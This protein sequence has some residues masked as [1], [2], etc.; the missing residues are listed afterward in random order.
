[1]DDQRIFWLCLGW[2]GLTQAAEWAL[3]VLRVGPWPGNVVALVATAL[4]V[5]VAAY[6]LV[7]PRKARGPEQRDLAWW[8]AVAA[9]VLGSVALLV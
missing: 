7:R 8:A 3:A 4:I 1:M 9:A 2:F 6:A 5:V